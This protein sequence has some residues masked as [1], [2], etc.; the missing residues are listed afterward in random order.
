MRVRGRVQGVGFRPFVA[1][2]ARA[3]GLDGSVRNGPEGVELELEGAPAAIERL[4]A[5][6]RESPPPGA[7]VQTVTS[8][9]LAVTGRAGF[10]VRASAAGI[11]RAPVPVDA[12]PCD[13]CVRELFDA[14]SRRC[15]DPFISCARCGP[16]FS[17]ITQLPYDRAH[18]TMA[19]FELCAACRAEY[20]EPEDRRFHAQAI[21]CPRCGPQL[22]LWEGGARVRGD[23]RALIERVAE[24]LSRGAIAAIQGVGGFHLVVDA[25]DHGAVTRLRARKRRPEKPLAVLVSDLEMLARVAS[26]TREDEGLLRSPAAPIVLVTRRPGATL[27]AA[28]APDNQELG[29]MLPSSGLHHLLAR[30]LA[31]PLV[32]TSGN[33]SG[34][35]ICVDVEEARARLGSIA[36]VILGHDRA[37]V[38]PLDD[39]VVRWAAGRPLALRRGRGCA[40]L[41]LEV[42]EREGGDATL[43]VGAHL[44][45]AVCLA[46]DRA[47]IV[48]P[49]VG[50]L[51]G[52]LARRRCADAAQE[53]LTLYPSRATAI[54]CDA[55]PD[56]GSTAVARQLAARHELGLTPV[57]HHVAHVLACV[58]ENRVTEAGVGV[59]W[60]GAGLGDDGSSWGG[61]WF[62]FDDARALPRHV[63]RMRP[64]TLPG[65]DRAA[66]SP[67]RSALAVLF[68]CFGPAAL[69]RRLPPVARIPDGQRPLLLSLLAR[70]EPRTT[71]VGRLFDALASLLGLVHEASFEA[72]AA[73]RVEHA[74]RAGWRHVVKSYPFVHVR[75]HGGALEL[76]WRP[77]LRAAVGDI[78]AGVSASTVAA[79]FHETLARMIVATARRLEGGD[80]LA[81]AGGCFAN[82][83]L[84]ERVIELARAAGLRPVWPRA[85][86]PGD[87]GLAP[88]QA[89]YARRQRTR[90]A[91]PGAPWHA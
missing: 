34:E 64:F 24:A 4:I 36:D 87:G 76:D 90:R 25:T 39:S 72:Q 8:T 11:N 13:A 31:R 38:R 37:I 45:N 80:V 48:G 27:S 42:E 47:I 82:K 6:V 22:S 77:A 79:R 65:G 57:Q 30:R 21:S 61:E 15:G 74:A 40:P 89:E 81:L 3:L 5:A 32:A 44:K 43:A 85:L 55:H 1:R 2:A 49:H 46:L 62:A 52:P 73:T 84:L 63:A 16:R 70:A 17:I 91:A 71:S 53:L 69:A 78:E 67:W 20:E 12:A 14:G 18:T 33:R 88:G 75:D 7:D 68:V 86:P 51:D 41:V 83:L 23:A 54:A 60:D 50:T 59:A 58:V 19:R 26:P 29:V 35:P 66:R 56:Y 10:R 28:V 9:P